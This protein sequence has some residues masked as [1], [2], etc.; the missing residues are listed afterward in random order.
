MKGR[1]YMLSD[2][3]KA[4]RQ[5]RSSAN[6]F[7]PKTWVV[8]M[9]VGYSSIA[10]VS[11]NKLF[12][13][14]MS[15]RKSEITDIND[16]LPDKEVIRYRSPDGTIYDVGSSWSAAR[17]E[18]EKYI[19]DCGYWEQV[20]ML[21]IL[22]ETALGVSL[23]NNFARCYNDE[24][25][26]AVC[27]LPPEYEESSNFTMLKTMLEGYHKFSLL[28][29][30]SSNWLKF[31]FAVKSAVVMPKSFANSYFDLYCDKT[32]HSDI[33]NGNPP[34]FRRSIGLY[35]HYFSRYS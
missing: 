31:D 22:T 16:I 33:I 26:R 34:M 24:T 30:G 9:D 15:V 29:A 28:P 20:D 6:P 13:I 17:E 7:V 32:T 11:P 5:M 35:L 10:A 4:K 14:P 27:C 2:I 21:R 18:R 8:S 1:V 3:L 23:F 12:S 25:I 19:S